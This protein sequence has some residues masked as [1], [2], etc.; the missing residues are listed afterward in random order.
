MWG[1]PAISD[2]AIFEVI[3][4]NYPFVIQSVLLLDK[5]FDPASWVF[6]LQTR[7]KDSLFLKLRK[8][9]VYPPAGEIPF[10]LQ[11]RV[12]IEEVL[13]PMETLNGSLWVEAF[14]HTFFIFPYVNGQTLDEIPGENQP[15]EKVGTALASI[16]QAPLPSPLPYGLRKENFI[17]QL[18]PDLQRVFQFLKNE[19]LKTPLQKELKAF[20]KKENHRIAPVI[21]GLQILRQKILPQNPELVIC[22][23]DIHAGNI[24]LSETGKLF[25]IDWDEPLIAPRERD[26][27]AASELEAGESDFWKGYNPDYQI[28]ED[29]LSYYYCE[30]IVRELAEY[31]EIIVETSRDEPTQQ[32]AWEELL[33]LFEP[34]Q[35]VDMALERVEAVNRRL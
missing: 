6:H 5:G 11:K 8:G 29:I 35:D 31:G 16:H 20:F 19:N 4:R 14:D 30:W 13:S 25:I 28:N 23:S 21:S 18:W 9:N 24:L 15:W 26:L 27:I 2:Q 3:E 10:Y 22:H 17:P 7:E 32:K 34:G 12:S 33:F 1:K